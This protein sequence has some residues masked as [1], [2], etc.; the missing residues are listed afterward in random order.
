VVEVNLMKQEIDSDCDGRVTCKRCRSVLENDKALS[1]HMSHDSTVTCPTCSLI[2]PDNCLLKIHQDT[3]K[4][5][6]GQDE[7]PLVEVVE[8]VKGRKA[9]LEIKPILLD[10]KVECN[11]CRKTFTNLNNFKTHRKYTHSSYRPHQCSKCPAN[12]KFRRHL[13]EHT[14]AVHLKLK[15]YV[16]DKCGKS[17]TKNENMRRH[18]LRHDPGPGPYLC[19]D[20]GKGFY[21]LENLRRHKLKH[22]GEKPYHCECGK[23]FAQIGGLNAH[24]MK[25]HDDNP[26]GPSVPSTTCR[27]CM[28][29][30]DSEF[31]KKNHLC[32]NQKI[33]QCDKCPKFYKGPRALLEHTLKA[34]EKRFDFLCSFCPK[35]FV[36]NASRAHHEKIHSDERPFQCPTCPSA[37]KFAQKLHQHQLDVH[38]GDKPHM[39]E[40]CGMRFNRKGSVRVHMRTHTGEKPYV[41]HC[42]KSYA[43][44]GDLSKHKKTHVQ[45]DDGS[46]TTRNRRRAVFQGPSTATSRQ[47]ILDRERQQLLLSAVISKAY[48][49]NK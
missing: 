45:D 18:R 44:S 20:C 35:R 37:F 46:E 6:S 34:H 2:F 30:F 25:M 33:Y 47:S 24:R 13:R 4:D 16:C 43:Q 49:Q 5:C 9:S 39:C 32:P 36:T 38:I 28:V 27:A 11:V 42:G 40:V 31:E 48:R 1:D 22:T 26:P 41:C 8:N 12:F 19:E 15:P 29:D 21:R 7:K 3:V 17:F 10:G 14:S 23:S